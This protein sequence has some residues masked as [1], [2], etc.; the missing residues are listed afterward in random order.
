[1][2]WQLSSVQLDKLT[3]W[4]LC[5]SGIFGQSSI[6][7]SSTFGTVKT[8]ATISG[9]FSAGAG[10]VQSTGFGGFQKQQPTSPAGM[11]HQLVHISSTR[12]YCCL[13]E[14]PLLGVAANSLIVT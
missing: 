7:S 8:Q 2:N 1:M 6:G 10:S 4:C 12:H 9:A 11:I 14:T 5:V 3:T 13:N